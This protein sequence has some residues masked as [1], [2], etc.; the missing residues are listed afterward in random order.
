MTHDEISAIISSAKS[1]FKIIKTDLGVDDKT[2][3]SRASI[4]VVL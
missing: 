3:M 2:D 1:N 4:R